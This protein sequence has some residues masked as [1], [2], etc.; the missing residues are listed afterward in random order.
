MPAV[1]SNLKQPCFFVMNFV[2]AD[3]GPFLRQHVKPILA[4]VLSVLIVFSCACYRGG[5]SLGSAIHAANDGLAYLVTGY[6]PTV[7]PRVATVAPRV[8]TEG[9]K[10]ADLRILA[11]QAGYKKLA[12]SGRRAELVAVLTGEAGS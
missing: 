8:A 3:Y 7:K 6:S 2:T 1:L 12:R 10:V 11:R 4:V 5:Y 9:L